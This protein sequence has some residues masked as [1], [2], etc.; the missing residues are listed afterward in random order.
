MP[1]GFL[2]CGANRLGGEEVERLL[3]ALLSHPRTAGAH[4]P[5]SALLAHRAPL[6]VARPTSTR[7]ALVFACVCAS[8]TSARTTLS[9][10]AKR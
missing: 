10:Y 4:G 3:N 9:R 6:A 5:V 2:V 8:A 7:C 1:P